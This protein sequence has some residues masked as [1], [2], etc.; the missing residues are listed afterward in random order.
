MADSMIHIRNVHVEG[1]KS[2]LNAEVKFLPGLNVIIGKNGA[3]KSNLLAAMEGLLLGRRRSILTANI[4][5]EIETDAG[6]SMRFTGHGANGKRVHA[7]PNLFFFANTG[8]SEQRYWRAGTDELI[9]REMA[10]LISISHSLPQKIPFLNLKFSAKAGSEDKD[11]GELVQEMTDP[12]TPYFCRAMIARLYGLRFKWDELL[13]AG[14]KDDQAFFE[15]IASSL[16]LHEVSMQN[17]VDH[18]PIEDVRLGQDC[19]V[20]RLGGKQLQFNNIAYEFKIGDN[21]LPFND[22][23]DG[24]Q[25]MVF[26]IFALSMPREFL[27]IENGEDFL[28]QKRLDN[29]IIFLEEPELGIHPH[30]LHQLLQFLKAQARKHQIIITT[31]SPQVL[32]ILGKEDLDRIII[33][34][35]D[36]KQGSKFEHL[37][38]A[39]KEKAEAYRKNNLLSDY[40]RFSDLEPRPAL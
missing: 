10:E 34:S 11:L 25:R 35:Y 36:P 2:I 18:T 38:P 23:S 39:Q 40:W 30:Q 13:D 31:H 5:V 19:S 28:L 16:G 20:V 15:A 22:L 14:K 33:A 3:G 6:Q 29:R 12:N 7:S 17:I 9:E 32:D 26:I 24:T 21:W 27:P 1:Y 8:T 37:N 4:E